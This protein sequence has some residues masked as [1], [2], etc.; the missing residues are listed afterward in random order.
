M[1][2]W[3]WTLLTIGTALVGA[4]TASAGIYNPGEVDEL[5]SDFIG[6]PGKNFRDVIIHLRS[7]RVPLPQVDNPVRRRFLFQDELLRKF[8]IT[9][10]KT[11]EDR[12]QASAVLIRRRKFKEAEEV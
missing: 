10:L 8:P 4:G 12:L 11:A 2:C 5:Y 9:D 7:I 1:R 3:G 6:P